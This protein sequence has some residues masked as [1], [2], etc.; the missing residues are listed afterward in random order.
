MSGRGLLAMF[1]LLSTKTPKSFSGA[2]LRCHVHLVLN[3]C[4]KR[5]GLFWNQCGFRIWILYELTFL[6]V[7]CKQNQDIEAPPQIQPLPQPSLPPAAP[8]PAP[9]GT[10]S[11]EELIQQSQWNLQQ[12]EQQLL[13][14]RQVGV[15]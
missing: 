5:K 14:M 9:Q 1:S 10:P 6:T 4:I 7:L 12:Q 13:A 8:I 11:V 15:E 2:A 3:H